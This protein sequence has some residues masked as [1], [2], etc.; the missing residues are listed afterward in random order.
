M[1]L[2]QRVMAAGQEAGL[3]RIGVCSTDPF[4]EVR[5]DLVERRAAG[6]SSSLSFTFSRPDI[7]SDPAAAFPWAERIVVAGRAYVPEAGS[8]GPPIPGTGRVARFAESDHYRPLLEG[9][10]AMAMVLEAGGFRAEAISDDG[11]LVDRAV[12]RRAGVG[13]WGKNT[14]ILAPEVG[15]WMLL[16]SVLTDAPLV[17]SNPMKRDC[18]TCEACLPAC[19]TGALIAPGILDARRCL[20]ALAQLPGPIPLQ[21]REAMGDRLYGCDDCLDACPPGFRRVEAGRLG[22]GRVDLVEILE[23]PPE[24]IAERFARFF[25]PAL[26]GRYLQRNA[27]VALGNGGDE[28]HVSL[29]VRF[30]HSGDSMLAGHAAWALGT[31]GGRAARLALE[32]AEADEPQLAG[33]IA[34]AIAALDPSGK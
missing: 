6:L 15:P 34:S 22:P 32:G 30:L 27:L 28:S 7:A 23:S 25:I 8:P 12:A 11:R 14:M 33:E 31:I 13:W 2:T 20:A 29:L 17:E 10:R 3:D 19:P 4:P 21:F 26:D 1:D 18:G 9:L 5:H 24:A 16:G